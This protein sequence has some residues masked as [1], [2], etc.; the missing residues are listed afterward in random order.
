M[1]QLLALFQYTELDAQNTIGVFFRMAAFF[2]L[3]PGFGEQ[4]IPTRVKLALAVAMTAVVAPVIDGPPENIPITMIILTEVTSGLLL[5]IG[6]RLFAMAL[7]T[8]GV[9]AAQA[10]SLSQFLGGSGVDPMPAF[11]Y[12][13]YLSGITLAMLLGLHVKAAQFFIISY[14][15]LAFGRFAAASDVAEWGMAQV[16]RVF[17]L[18]FSL[19][20]PFLIVSFLYNVALG[21][22][23]KA[24]P[25]LMVAFV[26]APLITA[27]GLIM[28][29][30]SVPVILAVW[31]QALDAFMANP[32]M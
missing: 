24:M 12:I 4:S 17:T 19:A 11:G 23:N 3:I 15:F 20:A 26:G 29:F 10:T 27:G 30:V 1:E 13:L 16:A 9:I 14:D 31:M 28:L 5:G 7:Q 8:A 22:I 2:S 32:L 21:V 6:L 25:Q 18:A